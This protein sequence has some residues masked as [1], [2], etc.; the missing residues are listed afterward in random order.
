MSDIKELL[1]RTARQAAVPPSPETVEAD[2]RRGRAA[3]AR[4]RRRRAIAYSIGGT[5]AATVLATGTIAIVGA[6]GGGETDQIARPSQGSVD[7]GH[8]S[9]EARGSGVRLVAYDGEQLDGFVVERI[10]EGWYLQ[11]STPAF[12]TI[13][14]K[15]DT[16]DPTDFQGKLVVLL[17]SESVPQE[18]PDGEPVTVGGNDGVISHAADA[19]T[20]T[21]EDGEGHIVQVQAWHKPLGWSTEQLVSFAEGV[22]VTSHVEGNYG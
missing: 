20:L 21:F 14:P 16:T 15:G 2:L 22:T 17:L 12:L 4:R 10:P 6:G 5:L 13:A 19:D 18:L 9:H 7:T 11:G 3:L 8:Q 1:E